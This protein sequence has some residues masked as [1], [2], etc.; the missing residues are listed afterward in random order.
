[1]TPVR[2][3]AASVVVLGF[4]GAIAAPLP[5]SAASAA[6]ERTENYAAQSGAEALRIDKLEIRAANRGTER[7][8]T[9]DADDDTQESGGEGP[10][11]RILGAGAA[12]IDPTT[13]TGEDADTLSEGIGILGKA[14][15]D[16]VDPDGLI[17]RA[18][19]EP[20]TAES[21][22]TESDTGG[23]GGGD[24]GDEPKVVTVREVGL[25]EARTALIGPAKVKS[26]AVARILD[27]KS[28]DQ[29][30][31]TKPV[32]QQ[33]PPTNAEATKRSTG[34]GQA[35]PLKVGA[36][37]MSAHARWDDG[38]A[39][40]RAAGETGRSQS[41]VRGATIL[42]GAETVLVRV[43]EK[44]A[45]VSS[46][47]LEGRGGSARTVASATMTAGRI[48]LAG[49]R[50]R[51]RVLRAPALTATMSATEGGEV[52]YEPALIEVSG[53]GI[54]T[55]RLSTAGAEAEFT[56]RPDRKA[57]EAGLLGSGLDGL[58]S[59]SALPLPHVPG[60]PKVTMPAA[61]GGPAAESA[62]AAAGSTR[63]RIAL[64]EVRKATKGHAVAARATAIT[65]SL[66]QVGASDGYHGKPGS[67]S[68]SL[69]LGLMEAAAVAPEEQSTAGEAGGLPI[70]GPRVTGLAMGGAALLVTGMA[71][72]LLSM[73]RRRTRQ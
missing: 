38:M 14:V 28:G 1:M 57:M 62:P 72:V 68:L 65:V 36:G 51:V 13:D 40:A 43:P 24:E 59:G 70:T 4:A 12:G 20:F 69:A 67:A 71:A 41:S 48:D 54:A 29:A 58:T 46:T 25:G 23:Q 60:L 34:G 64:G 35:G 16:S 27:G 21:G 22:T 42:G 61:I 52:S 66:D 6:C 39:C 18:D 30:S 26:A 8:L 49:G 56:V 63:V 53:D 9:P 3:L 7:P 32:V 17:P 19:S 10:A 31:W 45:G 33:A 5:A 11:D 47:A 73:R 55:E 44:L 15:L 50:V 37:E 2:S